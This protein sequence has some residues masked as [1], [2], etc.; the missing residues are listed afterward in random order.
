MLTAA[1][2]RDLVGLVFP[3]NICTIAVT[4]AINGPPGKGYS[5]QIPVL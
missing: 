3:L 4:G 5:I 1:A 2:G